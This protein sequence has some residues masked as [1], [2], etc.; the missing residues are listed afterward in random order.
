VSW[1]LVYLLVTTNGVSGVYWHPEAFED[2]NSCF[3][4]RE[5]L[6]EATGSDTGYFPPGTQAFCIRVE[7]K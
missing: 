3:M 1:V 6:L 7:K 5:S 4:M 2:M